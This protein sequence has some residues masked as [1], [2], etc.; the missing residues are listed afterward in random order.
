MVSLDGFHIPRAQ[1]SSAGMERRGAPWTFDVHAIV[2][3]V[4]RLASGEEDVHAPGF[5]HAA[6]DPVPDAVL[7]PALARIVIVEHNYALLDEPLW[8]RIAS[9]VR[10]SS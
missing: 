6:K 7:V 2:D 3:L 9:L 1:L 10:C 5:S 4:E 8:R